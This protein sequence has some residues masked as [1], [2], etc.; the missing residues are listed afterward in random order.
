MRILSF[1][2]HG[3]LRGGTA[4]ATAAAV[5]T[6]GLVTQRRPQFQAL[7][8]A[9]APQPQPAAAVGSGS[10]GPVRVVS[11]NV[12]SQALCRADHFTASAPEDLDPDIRLNR[13]MAQLEPHMARE[14]VICLQEV[15]ATWL[16]TLTPFFESRGY[17]LSSGLYGSSFSD[18]M[19][20]ALAWPTRRFA[21]EQVDV[22]R[23]SDAKE[24][25]KPPADPP[26]GPLRAVLARSWSLMRRLF[27]DPLVK[28][29][30]P[31]FDSWAEA[32]KRANILLSARLRCKA[33][34]A[35]FCVSTYHMP[36]LFGS[37][38]KVQAR[39]ARC[40]WDAPARA[41]S[42]TVCRAG[43]GHTRR[44]R[45]AARGCIRG[46]SAVRPRGRF[47]HPAR[48]ERPSASATACE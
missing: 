31:P 26:R 43:D 36:C 25:P 30:A 19:G 32:R 24:W 8:S 46:G 42:R 44:A 14:S 45:R 10:L 29:P 38:E 17:T 1:L 48:C 3:P 37:D 20:V 39:I 27:Y 18:Y 6:S 41:P 22:K 15:S 21:S 9:A 11:Y 4:I 23:A 47:Q 34:G 40:G 7:C 12:L 35:R 33:S 2:S 5:V 28:R 16:G 13:V